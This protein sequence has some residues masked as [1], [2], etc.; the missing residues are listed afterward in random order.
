M[1]PAKYYDKWR[2]DLEFNIENY[3]RF[4]VTTTLIKTE[5]NLTRFTPTLANISIQYRKMIR[6]E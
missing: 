2:M 5:A 3:D 1:R 6:G 4:T